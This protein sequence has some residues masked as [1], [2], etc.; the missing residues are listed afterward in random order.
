M[1]FFITAGRIPS[2]PSRPDAFRP[3]SKPTHPCR[4]P[5]SQ[6]GSPASQSR[7]WGIGFAF[8]P[9]PGEISL[10]FAVNAATV[11]LPVHSGF[12]RNPHPFG[13]AFPEISIEERDPLQLGC[14][15]GDLPDEIVFLIAAVKQGGRKGFKPFSFR[16]PCG[17]GKTDEIAMPAPLFLP[18]NN[19]PKKQIERIILLQYGFK[20]LPIG[21]G[22]QRVKAPFVLEIGMN[23]GIVEETADL[24]S[25]PAEDAQGI[26]R[27]WGA[28]DMKQQFQGPIPQD[29]L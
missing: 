14:L 20:S 8:S 26:D 11:R 2:S 23:V 29:I 4:E 19:L 22:D 13:P 7:G 3:V 10:S 5:S 9:A 15:L 27:A 17:L 28:A 24:V 6:Q 21:K 1:I 16:D 12:L 25:F 18:E